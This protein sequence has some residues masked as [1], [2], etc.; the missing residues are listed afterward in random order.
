MCMKNKIKKW[1]KPKY[2][3]LS[4]DPSGSNQPIHFMLN[5]VC[6]L[7]PLYLSTKHVPLTGSWFILNVN[8]ERPF[9]IKFFV[10]LKSTFQ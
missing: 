3:Y 7:M 9:V 2:S 8:E 4:I 5:D 6:K 1:K 10:T